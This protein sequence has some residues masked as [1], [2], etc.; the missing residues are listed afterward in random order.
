MKKNPA[1]IVA[2]L[3]L[4]F[5]TLKAEPPSAEDLGHE[6]AYKDLL[7]SPDGQVLAYSETIKGEHRLYLLNL[8]TKEKFGLELLGNNKAL[9]HGSSFFWANNHRFVYSAMG[10]YTAIDRDGRNARSGIKGGRLLHR[11]QDDK[12]GLL[13]MTGFDVEVKEGTGPVTAYWAQH[14][15][16]VQR[17]NPHGVQGLSVGLNDVFEDNSGV[18]REVENPGSVMDWVVDA[19][20]EV[21]A[22]KEIRNNKY[23]VL[24]R[25]SNEGSWESLPGLGWEDPQAYPLGFSAEGQ[26]LYVG[27]VSP[28]GTW[29]VYPYDLAKLS[30][31]EPIVAHA[32]YDIVHPAYT[33]YAN[34]LA[35][36]ALIFSPKEKR[37]LGIRYATE[38]PRMLWLDEGLAGVQAALDQALPRKINTITSLSDDLQR[39]VILSWTAQDPGTFYL[40]DR[41]TQ[42]LEQLMSSMPWIDPGK[43]ADMKPFRFRSRD[44]VLVNGYLTLPPG[45]EASNL[46]LVVLPTGMQDREHWGFDGQVQF[47]ATR[48]YAVMQVSHRGVA[49]YGD[50][51]YNAA[52]GR[53]DRVVPTDIAD[54]VRWAIGQKAVDPAR[55]AIVGSGPYGSYFVLQSL[56]AEPDLYCCAVDN[57]GYSD[58]EK[59]VDKSKLMPDYFELL[60][61]RFGASKSPEGMARL[62]EASPMY[63]N[64]KI[65]TPLLVTYNRKNL[66]EDWINNQCKDLAAALKATGKPVELITDYDEPYGYQTMAKYLNDRLAFVSRYMPADK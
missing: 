35:Q 3:V 53:I 66:A 14:R 34:G 11:F 63:H 24:Y 5:A 1:W 50:A 29:A 36:S 10:R 60:M 31:G 39:M 56:I 32:K 37:L 18:I 51:F 12:Y 9:A 52:N 38:F 6:I 2:A 46:P 16:F 17:V 26:T 42:K 21:R 41:R 47:W 30:L 22:G 13:L 40:F 44:G 43:M 45:R 65:R 15:P 62:R 59:T 20:G 61:E 33:G 19:A 7:L 25:R 28:A 4:L 57:S 64:E 8:A 58:W 54:A 48:G 49:G 55:V 27:R 23:H